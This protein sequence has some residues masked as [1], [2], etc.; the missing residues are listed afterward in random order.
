MQVP[1]KAGVSD[2]EGKGV[3][4]CMYGCCS[5]LMYS[6]RV[7][8]LTYDYICKIQE[9]RRNNVNEASKL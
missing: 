9:S 7:N 8:E 6:K 3:Y 1:R 5:A 2:R 4:V